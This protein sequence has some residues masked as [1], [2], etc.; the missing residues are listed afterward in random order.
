MERGHKRSSNRID[1]L[2]YFRSE[3]IETR[4][5]LNI[6]IRILIDFAFENLNYQNK[7]KYGEEKGSCERMKQT[8]ETDASKS[9]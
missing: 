4:L 5:R 3:E 6:L 2:P 7:S 9:H 8:T 1:R